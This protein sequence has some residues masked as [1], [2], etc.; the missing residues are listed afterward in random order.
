MSNNL[1]RQEEGSP[2]PLVLTT[3]LHSVWFCLDIMVP[4]GK[5]PIESIDKGEAK[6]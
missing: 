4:S 1:A 3:L 6:L 2:N 5:E